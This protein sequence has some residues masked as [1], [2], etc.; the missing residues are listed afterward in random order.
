M[1]II[2]RGAE[3]KA[4]KSQVIVKLPAMYG[5]VD[6]GYIVTIRLPTYGVYELGGPVQKNIN[7]IIR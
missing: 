3:R 7:A 2:W 4:S 6:I 5:N 1:H